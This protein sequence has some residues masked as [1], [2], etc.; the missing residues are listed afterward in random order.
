MKPLSE[1]H[2]QKKITVS[3]YL[4][5]KLNPTGVT[6][7]EKGKNV[8]MYPLYLTVTYNRKSTQLKSNYGLSYANEKDVED[9]LTDFEERVI[10]KIIRNDASLQSE[11]EEYDMKGLKEKY[12]TF[13]ISLYTYLEIYLKPRLR[14]EILKTNDELLKALDLSKGVGKNSVLLL[15]RAAEKLFDNFLEKMDSGLMEDIKTYERMMPLLRCD[16]YEFPTLIDW[17]DGSIREEFGTLFP[18]GD[19]KSA[20]SIDRSM[21]LV[22]DAV[23]KMI[24]NM[25]KENET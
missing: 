14:L 3:F 7:N 1:Q 18:N 4:N 2:K 15:F 21:K 13:A 6:T 20:E 10:A 5:R 9:G 11:G 8:N 22:G 23:M 25:A 16:N 12:E 19:S 17:I 24:K